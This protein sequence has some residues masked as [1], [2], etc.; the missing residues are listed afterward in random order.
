MQV[1]EQKF[2]ADTAGTV[3]TQ[4]RVRLHP[5]LTAM[6]AL[7]DGR[8][9]DMRTLAPPTGRGYEYLTGTGWDFPAELE[10]I[11]EYLAEK[12][13][14]PSV[15]AGD[16][17]PG[18]RPVQPVAH[19]PRVDRA[20]HRAGPRARLRGGLRGHL[21]RH[22]RQ[23]RRAA[24]RLADHERDR[25]PH[26]R[27]R[28]GHDRLGR[29]GRAGPVVRHR[30]RRRARRLPA[31]PAHGAAEGPGPLQRLR[32][33]RLARRTCRSSAWRTCRCSPRRTAR[34]STS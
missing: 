9:D 27:A 17:R 19:H 22:L 5:S 30:A 14:A 23:A 20:R 24:V 29:R 34:R 32:V 1:K 6:K 33:R 10:R 21:V 15:E 16:V 18:D 8:F 4:Q 13:A 28:P 31:R 7:P 26:R 12:L 25:R 3:T 2:Y 11:P